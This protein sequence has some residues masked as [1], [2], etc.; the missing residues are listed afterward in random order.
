MSNQLRNIRVKKHFSLCAPRPL[1]KNNIISGN[2]NGEMSVVWHN[3]Q[4]S[5]TICPPIIWK[6]NIS[7]CPGMWLLEQ[8]SQHGQQDFKLWE[9]SRNCI[10]YGKTK[11]PLMMKILIIVYILSEIGNGKWLEI[12]VVVFSSR[13]WHICTENDLGWLTLLQ[14]KS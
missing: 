9:L 11:A 13:P 10:H 7:G 2:L 6:A 5:M 14:I 1:W 12:R 3:T 4:R 8:I